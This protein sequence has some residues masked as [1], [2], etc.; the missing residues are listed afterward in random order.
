[1]EMIDIRHGLDTYIQKNFNWHGSGVNLE[2]GVMGITFDYEGINYK[3]QLHAVA[4]MG[5][6]DG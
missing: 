1:M 3:L 4:S 2:T 5:K 6:K